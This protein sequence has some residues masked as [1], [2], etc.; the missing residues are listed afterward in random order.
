MRIMGVVLF[1]SGLQCGGRYRDGGSGTLR[2]LRCNPTSLAETLAVAAPKT[3]EARP[4]GEPRLK[5][6]D[7]PMVRMRSDQAAALSNP[8]WV[9]A[10]TPSSRPISSTILP[11][12]T[13]T[14]VGPVDRKS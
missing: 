14:T 13:L 4:T 8:S 2:F 9:S 5:T 12:T 6:S 3:D 10:V 7:I 11:S 1:L